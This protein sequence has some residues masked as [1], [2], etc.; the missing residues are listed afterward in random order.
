MGGGSSTSSA[1]PPIFTAV[2]HSVATDL[3]SLEEDI[4]HE[5]HCVEVCLGS[6]DVINLKVLDGVLVGGV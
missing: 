6:A 1:G 2:D 5:L 4:V 3:A